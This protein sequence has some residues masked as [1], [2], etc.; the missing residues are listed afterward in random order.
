MPGLTDWSLSRREL[1]RKAALAGGVLVLP[2][3]LLVACGDDGG[4][5]GGSDGGNSG[6]DGGGGTTVV[7][8]QLDW[9]K[10][11][12]FAGFYFADSQGWYAEEGLEVDLLPGA[13]VA[14]HEAVVAGGGAEMGTSSFL[15]RIVDAVNA[16]SDLVVVGAG[17]Q[18][19]PIGLMSMAD[20]PIQT[21]EDILGKRIGLAGGLD[22]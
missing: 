1:L 12:Q 8:Y 13:D 22:F 19:S 2:S 14:S 10:N 5:G 7:R 16:G 17:L 6:G 21:A 9:I 3:G 11:S 20:N 18:Q 4:D 15:S